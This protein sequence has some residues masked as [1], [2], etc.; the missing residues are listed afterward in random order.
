MIKTSTTKTI[1]GKVVR[2]PYGNWSDVDKGIYVDGENVESIFN[3]YIGKKIKVV[4]Q[5]CEDNG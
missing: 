5:E 4:I 1:E 3:G 2:N